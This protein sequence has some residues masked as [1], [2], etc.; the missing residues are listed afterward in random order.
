[1]CE[2]GSRFNVKLFQK[3]VVVMEDT[4]IT[5]PLLPSSDLF[6]AHVTAAALCDY[7]HFMLPSAVYR[8]NMSLE[9]GGNS[10]NSDEA[11]IDIQLNRP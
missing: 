6:P 7:Y 10:V 5:E 4:V 1:M 3:Q 8:G 9:I 2:H 11:T